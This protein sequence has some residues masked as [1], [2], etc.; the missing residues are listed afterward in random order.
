[1]TRLSHA[2]GAIACPA[3]QEE[4]LYDKEEY[5]QRRCGGCAHEPNELIYRLQLRELNRAQIDLKTEGCNIKLEDGTSLTENTEEIEKEVFPKYIG[6]LL[7]PNDDNV[8]FHLG[9]ELRSIK[10]PLVAVS[11]D[12]GKVGVLTFKDNRHESH[13]ILR[14]DQFFVGPIE[15][16]GVD[17][18][19]RKVHI[20]VLKEKLAGV[21]WALSS[22][23]NP[24]SAAIE[25]EMEYGVV[26]ESS[27][28]LKYSLQF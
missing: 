5:H 1:M 4:I 22:D 10:T 13:I 26:K 6:N 27:N 14:N 23:S 11:N 21:S 18:G 25:D 2:Y 3:P 24:Q 8:T 15:A 12:G 17:Y 9:G 20:Y 19:D 28:L 7:L 16:L